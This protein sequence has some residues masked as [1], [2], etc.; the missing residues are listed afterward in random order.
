MN[1][2]NHFNQSPLKEANINI[3]FLFPVVTTELTQHFFNDSDTVIETCY[4]FPIPREA[5]LGGVQIRIGEHSYEGQ[6]LEKLAADEKYEEGIAEGKRAVLIKDVGD[7]LYELNLGNLAPR[8]SAEISLTLHQIAT[9]ERNQLR[10]F[11]PTFVT[12]HYGVKDF[13]GSPEPSTNALVSY[14]FVAN[15]YLPDSSEI[16][17]SSHQIE[18]VNSEQVRFTGFLN[19]DIS[20][21][22]RCEAIVSSFFTTEFDGQYATLGSIVPN[23]SVL[24]KPALTNSGNHD[25]PRAVQLLVDCS[26]SMSGPSITHVAQGLQEVFIEF[27][28][29]RPVNLIEYGSDAHSI[30]DYPREATEEFTDALNTLSADLGGT[31]IELALELAIKQVKSKEMVS[32]IVLLTDGQVWAHDHFDKL[33]GEAKALGIRIFCIGVGFA[34]SESI[35]QR[36]AVETGG[37]LTLVNPH[38]N[39]ADALIKVFTQSAHHSLPAKIYVH[40]A[41]LATHSLYHPAFLYQNQSNAVAM[42]THQRPKNIVAQQE[43]EHSFLTQ[44]PKLNFKTAISQLVAKLLIN[45]WGTSRVEQATTLATKANIISP[46]TSY[47][48]VGEDAVPAAD[49]MPE[50]V[51][52]PQMDKAFMSAA[53]AN[54]S[55]PAQPVNASMDTDFLEVPPFLRRRAESDSIPTFDDDDLLDALDK[56]LSRKNKQNRMRTLNIIEARLDRRNGKARPASETLC[57]DY[58]VRCGF[59]IDEIQA[60]GLDNEAANCAAYLIQL[61]E[62]E[63]HPFNQRVETLLKVKS[64]FAS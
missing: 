10:Y 32:D 52:V 21:T 62:Q 14:P 44:D 59:D 36:L 33:I 58:L 6:V 12:P 41:E 47:T 15:V 31:E 35:L 30:Y 2:T 63:N 34:I 57:Y 5:V 42:I 9:T 50:L 28:K 46:F 27:P 51:A 3:R 16:S 64:N 4:H 39:M 48:M 54:A 61:A 55:R 56:R 11:L 37:C 1:K 53:P 17:N 8:E 24:K 45:K 7:G 26:G 43:S 19:Q 40:G 60:F 25:K 13:F 22:L 49:G 29:N 23:E 38:E 18:A 20:F